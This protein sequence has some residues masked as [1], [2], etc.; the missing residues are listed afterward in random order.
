MGGAE[1]ATPLAAAAFALL[2]AGHCAAMCG[3][4]AAALAL[5]APS[6]RHALLHPLGKVFGYALAGALA[7]ALGAGL[8]ALGDAAALGRVLRTAAGLLIALVGLRILLDRPPWQ[9][10]ERF[11]LAV[12]RR[13]LAPLAER[14]AGGDGSAAAALALGALWGWLPCGLSWTALVAAAASGSAAQGALLMTA[15]G[16][17]TL[18]ALG[19]G[20]LLFS[21]WRPAAPGWRRAAGA[22]LVVAGLWTA[23]QPWLG[24]SAGHVHG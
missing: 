20:A 7:G 16:L 13:T 14:L 23:A 1:L 22:L 4:I 8:I 15:F 21:G 24:A 12:W 2:G 5:R 3:G 6:P 17:G 18:P 9:P 10:L 11:A 19:L